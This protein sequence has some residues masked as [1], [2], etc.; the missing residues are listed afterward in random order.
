LLERGRRGVEEAKIE[1]ARQAFKGTPAAKTP[2]VAEMQ[3]LWGAQQ[4][5]AAPQPLGMF[6]PQSVM[7]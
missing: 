3:K 7:E 1:R 4:V 5:P 6:Q 2:E